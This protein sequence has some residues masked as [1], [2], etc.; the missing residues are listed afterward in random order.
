MDTLI[1]LL[2]LLNKNMIKIKEILFRI[3]NFVF[4]HKKISFAFL[5]ILIIGGYFGYKSLNNTS[6]ETRYILAA[7]EKGIITT[8]VSGT[9]QVSV[10]NQVDL[11]AK[12]SGEIVY[13]NAKIGQQVS[14]GTLLAQIDITDAQKSIRDAE[15][16][17]ESAQITLEKLKGDASLEIPRNKQ[18][19]Q[20]DLAKAYEDGYNTV[21][22]IFLDLPDIMAGLQDIIYGKT[23]NNYQENI[24]FYSS[25]ADAKEE[26]MS[27]DE[28]ADESYQTARTNYDQSFSDYKATTRFSDNDAIDSIINKTYDTVKDI[29]QAIK[30]TNNL[31]QFYKDIIT[32]YDMEIS[33]IAETHL[34]DLNSYLSKTN[35][36]LS[37]LL[38]AK[39]TIKSD[40]EAISD[41]DLD[42]RSQELS[43]KQKERALQEAKDTLSNYYIYSPFSGLISDVDIKK[44]DDVSSGSAVFS[45]ITN[46]GIAEITLS[47]VDIANVKLGQKSI[48]TFDAIEDLTISGT[49][50][51]MDVVGNV[52]SGVVSYGIKVAFDTQNESIKP[53]MTTSVTVINNVKNDVL[54]APS[55]A[56]KSQGDAYYVQVLS[57]T[58]DLT[59]KSNSIKGVVSSTTPTTKTVTIGLADDTNTEITGGLSEGDQIVVRTS[60]GTATTTTTSS[61]KSSGNILNVGGGGARPPQ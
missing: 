29:S 59:D 53:G 19:A 28:T 16:S 52:N 37:S 26:D 30:D 10:S 36:G 27:Y 42:L 1:F 3:K 34:S 20:D 15:E 60:S 21:S 46:Q 38:S 61:N 31:I 17:L 55:A 41:S 18:E 14:T 43:Y 6:E 49:V 5:L 35:S 13:L 9:G 56:I 4:K 48:L 54:I 25:V 39:S 33:S 40:K 51:E 57:N 32:K 12:A 45:I 24:D 22:T 47:E 7:V 8:S 23:F 58:Y 50:S 11:K 44:G 2:I